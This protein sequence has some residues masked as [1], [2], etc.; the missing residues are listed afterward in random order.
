[1]RS[2]AGPI[3]ATLHGP[4]RVARGVDD[5]RGVEPPDLL[6]RQEPGPALH[7]RECHRPVGSAT[8]DDRIETGCLERHTERS[9][10]ACLTDPARE[11][12]L[13][14]DREPGQADSRVPGDGARGEHEDRLRVERV[15]SGA[16]FGEQQPRAEE[17]T[18]RVQPPRRLVQGFGRDRTAG[19]VDAEDP[20]AVAGS[21]HAH[22]SDRPGRPH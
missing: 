15:Q 14:D 2:P 4:S 22:L 7:D 6:R 21:W 3:A 13:A 9:F 10:R 12:R 19:Q 8:D 20:A 11:R 1:V 18:A 5:G 17:R 16:R